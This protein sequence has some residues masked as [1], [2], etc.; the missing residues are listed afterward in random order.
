MRVCFGFWLAAGSAF[1]PFALAG[2]GSGTG[3]G[4]SGAGALPSAGSAF[5]PYNRRAPEVVRPS[6]PTVGNIVVEG[7]RRIEPDTVLSY[8]SVKVGDPFDPSLVNRSLKTLFATGLFADV[9]LRREGDTLVVRVVENPIINRIAFEGNKRID[10]D[11]LSQE[12]QLRPPDRLHPD[13]GAERRAP[14]PGHLPA[15][16][17]VCGLGG[18]EGDPA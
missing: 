10:D 15:V 8:L 11:I 1:R 6:G 2:C 4:Y 5:R 13:P 9:T 17:T 18:A 3:A 12:V 7:T 16:G 14:H